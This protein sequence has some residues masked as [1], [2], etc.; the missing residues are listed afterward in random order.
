MLEVDDDDFDLT[1]GTPNSGAITAAARSRS[2]PLPAAL[3][4][5]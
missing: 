5:D 1:N 4:S 2:I 3:P